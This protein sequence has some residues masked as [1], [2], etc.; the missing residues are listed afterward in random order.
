MNTLILIAQIILALNFI[1][2]FFLGRFIKKEYPDGK[3]DI[4]FWTDMWAI[5]EIWLI[6]LGA[7]V[8]ICLVGI[9]LLEKSGPDY[10]ERYLG[11]KSTVYLYAKKLQHKRLHKLQVRLDMERLIH[12]NIREPLDRETRWHP[13]YRLLPKKQSGTSYKKRKV[14]PKKA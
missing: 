12:E 13:H 3:Y 1:G 6:L 8:P 5:R 2:A 7:G 9:L 11:E 14:T 10:M 4:P